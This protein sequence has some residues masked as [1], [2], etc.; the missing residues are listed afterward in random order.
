MLFRSLTDVNKVVSSGNVT[1]AL[2]NQSTTQISTLTNNAVVTVSNK[3]TIA[4]NGN[5]AVN[6]IKTFQVPPA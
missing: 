1:A 4:A 6:T 2:K 5:P 3:N